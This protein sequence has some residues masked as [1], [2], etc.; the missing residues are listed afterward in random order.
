MRTRDYDK[1]KRIK[2]AMMRLVLREGIDGASVSKIAREAGVSPATIYV[3]YD[4]KEAMLAEVFRECAHAPYGYVE[5]RLRSDMPAGELVETVVRG[6]YA[7][8]VEHEEVFSF[9]EQASRCPTLTGQVCDEK[10]SCGVLDLVRERQA[11]GE[12]RDCSGSVLVAVMFAPV[13]YLAMSR[14]E[15]GTD[16]DSQLDEL[17]SIVRDML[18]V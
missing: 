8:A 7:F 4:S 15:A 12:I 14:H 3:Y 9:T 2:E 10:C 13:R 11:R 5:G 18:V 17:V 16:W 1:Q 6:Y